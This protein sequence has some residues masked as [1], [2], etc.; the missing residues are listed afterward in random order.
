MLQIEGLS[1][2]SKSKQWHCIF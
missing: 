2:I 1:I